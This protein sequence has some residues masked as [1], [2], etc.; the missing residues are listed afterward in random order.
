M[1]SPLLD[2]DHYILR[3]LCD[4]LLPWMIAGKRVRNQWFVWLA[5]GYGYL[6]DFFAALAGLGIGSPI[7][8]LAT[9][10]PP[11]GKTAIDVLRSALPDGWFYA[12]LAALTLWVALR[13]VIQRQE[14]VARALL[15]KGYSRDMHALLQQL[16]GILRNPD[17]MPQISI[18][19]KSVDD[20]VQDAIRNEVW[21]FEPPLPTATEIDRELGA[22]V[23]RFRTS[24]MP[25]WA[26]PPA[27]A[28]L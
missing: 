6:G 3:K 15:A 12:G 5:G 4:E 28:I 1:P 17:P 8:A 16:E 25:R 24:Y 18:I 7:A 22:L 26:Q 9:G 13:L 27:G 20:K 23:S 21:P 19:Q 14:V 11:E 2:T 10:N